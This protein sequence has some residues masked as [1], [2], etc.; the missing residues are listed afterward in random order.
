MWFLDLGSLLPL[1]VD[2][3]GT[4]QGTEQTDNAVVKGDPAESGDGNGN[5]AE[6]AEELRLASGAL[7]GR[8]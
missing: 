8:S 4:A 7:T 5:I 3:D 6:I 1:A 2:A